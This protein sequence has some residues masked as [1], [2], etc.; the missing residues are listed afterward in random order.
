M[1][2]NVVK[3]SWQGIVWLTLGEFPHFRK[4]K[5]WQGEYA[6]SAPSAVNPP[7][8]TGPW[9][10]LLRQLLGDSADIIFICV[11]A[12]YQELTPAFN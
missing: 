2:N 3:M 4:E 7:Y 5:R 6:G 1:A 11:T 9:R 10:Y 12:N 8:K